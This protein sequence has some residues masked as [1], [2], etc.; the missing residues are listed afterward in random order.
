M[1]DMDAEP[2]VVREAVPG[3]LHQLVRLTRAF[4]DEDGFSTADEEIERNFRLLLPSPEAHVTAAVA[5]GRIRGFALTTNR[6]ILESGVVAELQDL[7][8]ERGL[9]NSGIG[10][11]LI[12]EAARWA[13]SRSARLFEIVVAP[14]GRDVTDLVRFYARRGFTDGGRRILSRPI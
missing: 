14:N 3:D 10:T 11:A 9:R 7:Y 13:Q 4:Y 1:V 8:V 6:M 12:A 5:D 2:W